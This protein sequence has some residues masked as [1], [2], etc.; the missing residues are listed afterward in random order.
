MTTKLTTSP[1]TDDPTVIIVTADNG[2]H[3]DEIGR[4][5]NHNGERGFQPAIFSSWGL[6][7]DVLRRL[8]DLVEE[9]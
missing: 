2:T 1:S 4:I 8:A 5:I 6:R 9:S 7:A 3:V